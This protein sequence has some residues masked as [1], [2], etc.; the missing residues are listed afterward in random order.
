[1]TSE[2]DEPQNNEPPTPETEAAEAQAGPQPVDPA[3]EIADLKDKLLRA[4]AESENIRRRAERDRQ[5]AA[6]YAITGFARELLAVSDNLRR[7]L[8]HAPA[9]DEQAGEVKLLIEGVD[10]TEK[11][12]LR[13]FEKHGIKRIEPAVGEKFDHNFHQAMFEIPTTE[14]PKGAILQVMQ[15]GYVIHGRLLRPAMVGIAKPEAG[16]ASERVDQTV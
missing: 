2:T 3:A 15:A 12:L 9:S 1:M 6:Q 13:I 5:D 14:H 10:L 7:A 4:M 8:E 16:A 11:E